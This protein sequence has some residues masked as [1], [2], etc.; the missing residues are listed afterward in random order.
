M[1]P[2]LPVIPVLQHIVDIHSK[3]KNAHATLDALQYL[4]SVEWKAG[5]KSRC[6][7]NTGAS[8]SSCAIEEVPD[9]PGNLL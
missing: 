5:K 6:H 9:L 4:A 7:S 8:D 3:N 1:N 2:M